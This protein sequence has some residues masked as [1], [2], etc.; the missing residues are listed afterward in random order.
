MLLLQ[1]YTVVS[2]GDLL[3]VDYCQHNGMTTIKHDEHDPTLSAVPTY[4]TSDDT[5]SG[6]QC[7][8]SL[9]IMTTD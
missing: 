4:S 1:K 7:F 8:A 6:S 3:S 2:D 9:S 5:V